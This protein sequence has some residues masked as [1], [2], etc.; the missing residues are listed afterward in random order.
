MSCDHDYFE[1]GY[2]LVI[3]VDEVG[4]GCL[5]GPVTC[6]A[7]SFR[8]TDCPIEGIKDSK[9][10]S[11]KKRRILSGH[12]YI[13]HQTTVATR[14]A[15]QID[16]MNILNATLDAMREAVLQC[17]EAEE[18][19]GDRTIV[20]V[21]GNKLIPDLGEMEQICIIRGDSKSYAIGCA[22]IVAKHTRDTHM[23]ELQDDSDYGFGRHKG[24]G[25]KYHYER[26][27]E[28]GPGPHHRTSFRLSGG[29]KRDSS[30]KK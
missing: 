6:A 15:R 10:V 29:D 1:R 8:P 21:D 25:T 14:S 7:V 27:T 20:L 26:L 28:C 24:Y 12:I 9:K 22:S 5:A 3:G 19:D 11:Q 18:R 17:A 4:R 13:T 2:T 23:C 30:S 16:E